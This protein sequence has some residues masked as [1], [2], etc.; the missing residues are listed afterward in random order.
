MTSARRQRKLPTSS[1]LL[2]LLASLTAFCAS[3]WAG[4]AATTERIVVDR[5]TG[6][7]MSGFDPVAYFT[8][9]QATMGRD[10]LELAY[11]GAVWR[12]RN[13]GNRAAFAADPHVYMPRFG[14]YDP[15]SLARGIGVPGHPEIWLIARGRLYLF[16]T[17]QARDTFAAQPE[18]AASIA[19]SKWPDVE[20]GLA[21]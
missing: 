3:P 2:T 15:I 10:E 17:R 8:N 12:F 16:S 13:E 4:R 5:L 1:I 18:R 7:A 14:G 21:L 9:A 20:R 6:L 19:E 11:G